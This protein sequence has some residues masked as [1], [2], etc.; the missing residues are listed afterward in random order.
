[1]HALQLSIQ[2][3]SRLY[4]KS[5]TCLVCF[6][7]NAVTSIAKR[8]ESCKED[9]KVNSMMNVVLASRKILRSETVF[10]KRMKKKKTCDRK[11]YKADPES[12][13]NSMKAQ[14]WFDPESKKESAKAQYWLD[15]ESKKDS[16]KAQYCLDP[17]SKK[18]SAKA[19]YWLDPERKKESVKAYY[20]QN[21]ELIFASKQD[22]YQANPKAKRD[23]SSRINSCR[24]RNTRGRSVCNVWMQYVLHAWDRCV[25][26]CACVR[27]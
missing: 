16:A 11:R 4:T 10:K 7:Q 15:P 26:S 27:L 21:R 5:L 22:Q 2:L 23:I 9:R 3:L 19:Q 25:V 20:D 18:E 6:L 24:K 1:M 13:K 12:K 14:Y 8:K 17:E